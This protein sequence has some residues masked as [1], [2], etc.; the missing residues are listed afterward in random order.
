MRGRP[1]WAC[2][3]EMYNTTGDTAA[4]AKEKAYLS[5]LDKDLGF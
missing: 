5:K 2:L 1:A 3:L 4:A